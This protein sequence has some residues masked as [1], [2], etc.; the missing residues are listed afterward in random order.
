MRRSVRGQLWIALLLVSAGCGKCGSTK[1]GGEEAEQAP[2]G[3]APVVVDTGV[4]EG[5]VRLAE[6]AQLPAYRPEQM[7]RKVLE[8]T[9]RAPLP[10][11]CSPPKTTDREPVRLGDDG[12]LEGV[13]LGLSGFKTQ[14]QRAP[15][16]HEVKIEDCRLTPRLVV[17]M[18]G[19]QLRV[20]NALDY[21][22]MP[23]YGDSPVVRTLVR[24][25]TYEAPLDKPGVSP[26]LC[27]FTAPC[28]RTDVVVMLH[29]LATVSDAQGKFRFD[30]F[31]ADEDVT[32][33]AWHPL[34]NEARVQVRVAAGETKR[35]ELVLIPTGSE[36]AAQEAAPAP[37]PDDTKPA[38]PQQPAK[39]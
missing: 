22:F 18:K 1:P 9:E 7:E 35:V 14:P 29:P 5:V 6:G 17:A 30:K 33:S 12:A 20:T 23:T 19:D 16:V 34:F 26:L 13:M 27:G 28:G 2:P 24:G 25:Q 38:A 3:S 10:D 39:P 31:P 36:P 21:P 15:M 37:K 8:H 4:V 32:L 11:S